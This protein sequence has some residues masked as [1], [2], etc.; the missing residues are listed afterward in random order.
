MLFLQTTFKQIL[1]AVWTIVDVWEIM[2]SADAL[3]IEDRYLHFEIAE[4]YSKMQ[5]LEVAGKVY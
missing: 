5:G 1:S 4:C 3:D 2:A